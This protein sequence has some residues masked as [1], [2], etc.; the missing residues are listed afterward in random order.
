LS[1]S[2]PLSLCGSLPGRI[3]L[4]N[5]GTLLE[6][7]PE[8]LVFEHPEGLLILSGSD[9]RVLAMTCHEILV[10]EQ[11]LSISLEVCR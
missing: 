2:S 3:L 4:E 11:V 1:V 10:G 6:Y 8:K 5:Y 9:L 7:T